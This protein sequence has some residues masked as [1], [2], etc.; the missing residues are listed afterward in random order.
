MNLSELHLDEPMSEL[1]KKTIFVFVISRLWSLVSGT[2][3]GLGRCLAR[4]NLLTKLSTASLSETQ[5][6]LV[7]FVL[8]SALCRTFRADLTIVRGECNTEHYKKTVACS[9]KQLDFFLSTFCSTSSLRSYAHSQHSPFIQDILRCIRSQ[10]Q[11][12]FQMC[13]FPRPVR[14]CDVFLPKI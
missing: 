6:K 5:P 12:V 7:F 9:N 11:L 4:S 13:S 14:F 10:D 1:K 3:R 2:F 8:F